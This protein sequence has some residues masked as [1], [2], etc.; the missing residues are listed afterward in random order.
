[1][2]AR[3]CRV[4][5]RERTCSAGSSGAVGVTTS[6]ESPLKTHDLVRQSGKTQ[7]VEDGALGETRSYHMGSVRA[8]AGGAGAGAGAGT[9]SR[10][11]ETLCLSET[12]DMSV[13]PYPEPRWASAASVAGVGVV[14]AVGAR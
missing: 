13:D 11:L 12:F 3:P 5:H 7:L 8:G 10:L 2:V 9:R 14:Q 1:M 6:W 4:P